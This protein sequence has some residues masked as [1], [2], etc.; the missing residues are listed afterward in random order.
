MTI[1]LTSLFPQ[2]SLVPVVVIDDADNAVPLAEALLEGGITSIEITLRTPQALDAIEQVATHVPDIITGSGTIMTPEQMS[3]AHDAGAQFQVSPGIT[4][5][6][7]C[8]AAEQEIA[9]LPGVANASN[10]LQVA[11]YGFTH[12]KFFPAELAGGL[13]MLKQFISVFPHIRFC[14]TGGITQQSVSN[15]RALPAV[16]AV[17]GSWLTPKDAIASKDWNRITTIAKESVA[18]LAA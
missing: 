4:D 17:G 10:I 7:A 15:Y 5:A 9:W 18:T 3:Q 1:T 11:E 16:F 8:H 12:M 6:L 13:A 2:F 14:P